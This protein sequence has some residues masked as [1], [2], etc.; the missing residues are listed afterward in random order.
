MDA[1]TGRRAEDSRPSD[2]PPYKVSL[3]DP[4]EI[5]AALPLL[6]GFRPRESV[7]LVSLTGPRGVRVG[8]TVRGDIPPPE[9]AALVADELVRS[10]LTAQ[11]EAVLLL[12]VSE[13]PLLGELPHRAL[14]HEVTLALHREG[15]PMRDAMLVGAQRWWSYDCPSACCRPDRG[16]RLPEG[17]SE[18]AAASVA[19]GVVV[20]DSREELAARIAPGPRAAGMSAVV[21]RVAAEAVVRLQVIGADA[22]AEE[23]WAAVQAGLAHTRAGTA[24]SDRAMARLLWGL[25]DVV[26][27]DRALQLALDEDPAVESLWTDCVCR[28]PR[29]YVPAPATL[30]AVVAWLRGNGAMAAVA[31]DRALAAQRTYRMAGLL[32]E[33]LR[34]CVP[35][36]ELRAVLV[37]GAADD[38]LPGT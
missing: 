7:V 15:L 25:R 20:A 14:V 28:A 5:A 13:E 31:L 24:L 16:N 30:L 32:R 34:Q 1:R 33:G 23:S 10:V 18:L 6:L 4:G 2:D 21:R 3:S 37:H 19:S 9:Y 35:P 22:T 11:P 29:K 26:V 27:R 38:V 36:S 17:T 12:V 8:L